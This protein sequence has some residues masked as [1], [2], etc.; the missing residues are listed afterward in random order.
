MLARATNLSLTLTKLLICW[1]L[2]KCSGLHQVERGG[3]P[4]STLLKVRLSTQV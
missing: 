4:K 3:G 2:L 1:T